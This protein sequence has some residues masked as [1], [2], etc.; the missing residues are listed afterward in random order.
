METNEIAPAAANHE[1]APTGPATGEHT[2]S[3]PPRADGEGNTRECT[4]W[5]HDPRLFE[6]E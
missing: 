2:P 4:H 5:D 6:E 1:P 3:C